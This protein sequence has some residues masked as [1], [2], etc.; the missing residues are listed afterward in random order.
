MAYSNFL[1]L[2]YWGLSYTS[3][4]TALTL[5]YLKYKKYH[6]N[7][8]KNAI[9]F[10][11]N[12]LII[13][14]SLT[15]QLLIQ[16]ASYNIVNACNYIILVCC[17]LIVYTSP[18]NTHSMYKFSFKRIPEKILL[19]VSLLLVALVIVSFFTNTTFIVYLVIYAMIASIL[20]SFIVGSFDEIKKI[21]KSPSRT[22]IIWLLCLL[23]FVLSS[24]FNFLDYIKQLNIH[25]VNKIHYV[26]MFYIVLNVGLILQ[27]RSFII[28][29][30]S[31]IKNHLLNMGLTKRELEVSRLLL[32]GKKYKD[33][34]ME[35]LISISTVKKHV[36][37]IYRKIDV[38][39]NVEF[40]SYINSL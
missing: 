31:Q 35:L 39:N 9:V 1:S 22:I 15:V 13:I 8:H 23:L 19:R 6:S 21:K 36:S 25:L 34:S 16:D 4:L 3:G 26:P 38:K 14:I 32:N 5:Y 40:I 33:I 24:I 30:S 18:L 2:L 37:N 10:N 17:A 29:L 28:P 27:L 20:Y 7:F 12:I 11:L